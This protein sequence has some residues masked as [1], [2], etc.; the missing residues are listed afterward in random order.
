MSDNN[1][2]K[3]KKTPI[4]NLLKQFV[5]IMNQRKI[6]FYSTMSLPALARFLEF[7]NIA[8]GVIVFSLRNLMKEDKKLIIEANVNEE[9]LFQIEFLSDNKG[10]WKIEEYSPYM[11]SNEYG[12][13]FIGNYEPYTE[14]YETVADLLQRAITIN[15]AALVNNNQ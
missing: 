7:Y 11:T 6:D 14:P 5:D 1:E 13:Y 4:K 8:G 9:F 3:K 10:N 12:E 15:T 2:Q